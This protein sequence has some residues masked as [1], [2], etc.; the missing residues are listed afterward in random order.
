MPETFNNL[1]K[2]LFK[3]SEDLVLFILAIVIL[4]VFIGCIYAFFRAIILFIFSQGAEDKIKKARDTI[5]YMLIG[6][7]A[8]VLLLFF[9]PTLIK[10]FSSDK[11]DT[12]VY[13]VKNVFT[14]MGDI[15]S[16]TVDFIAMIIRN[17]PD[18]KAPDFSSLKKDGGTSVTKYEL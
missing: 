8:T 17:Y 12:S 15:V 14:K 11:V 9:G 18:G 5:R 6:L 4:V 10:R 7:F 1:F 16:T 3:T 2:E 13:T